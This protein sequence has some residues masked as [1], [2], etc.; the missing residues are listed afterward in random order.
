MMGQDWVPLFWRHA[1]SR[2]GL[3]PRGNPCF[4]HTHRCTCKHILL[5][6]HNLSAMHTLCIVH[7]ACELLSNETPHPTHF[8]LAFQPECVSTRVSTR[9]CACTCMCVHGHTHAGSER[10]PDFFEDVPC[11]CESG[12]RGEP[13]LS[14]HDAAQSASSCSNAVSICIPP[15]HE[16]CPQSIISD[17]ARLHTH[18]TQCLHGL[19][20]R[21][22]G[23][24]WGGSLW[25]LCEC[26]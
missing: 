23:S 13:N 25:I 26:L 15:V 16:K 11:E 2:R 5:H 24:R 8:K 4:D 12:L 18:K 3:S 17:V 1:K 9:I 19:C 22:D 7:T 10:T 14:S 6:A 20:G 21:Y